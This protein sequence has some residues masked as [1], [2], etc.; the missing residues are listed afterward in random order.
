VPLEQIV[1]DIN[2]D[3]LNPLYEGFDITPLGAE[4]SSLAANAEA[5]ARASG[6]V[7]SPDPDPAQVFFIRSDQY[8]FVKR[9]VPSVFA[10]VGW[11]DAQGSIDKNKAI[12]E[13]WT[14]DHYHQPSDEWR[15]EYRADWAVKEARFQFLL[16][17]SVASEPQ[18]P[19][20]NAGDPFGAMKD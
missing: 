20:W 17:L 14:K 2:I 19:S 6:F 9:G 16:G 10:N 5:A 4:H 12:D 18:R 7:V 3:N 1:A 15:P 11:R 8:S 13:A